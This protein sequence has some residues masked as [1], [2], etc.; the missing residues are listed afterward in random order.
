MGWSGGGG[1]VG[2]HSGVK[3]R[4]VLKVYDVNNRDVLMVFDTTNSEGVDINN[5]D[6]HVGSTAT[7]FGTIFKFA[8]LGRST[9]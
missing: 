4:D 5:R 1:W 2:L 7:N 8:Q 9:C 3:K 6:A